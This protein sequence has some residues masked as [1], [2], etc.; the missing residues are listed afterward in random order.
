MYTLLF[1]RLVPLSVHCF[2]SELCTVIE[3]YE[4]EKEL[5]LT[6]L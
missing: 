6:K 2:H 3:F 5:S 1:L 4:S